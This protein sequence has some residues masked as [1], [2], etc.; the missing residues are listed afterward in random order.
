MKVAILIEIAERMDYI[1]QTLADARTEDGTV[2]NQAQFEHIYSNADRVA[3]IIN[4]LEV[5][6]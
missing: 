1:R 5:R 3:E 6:V 2:L 4:K